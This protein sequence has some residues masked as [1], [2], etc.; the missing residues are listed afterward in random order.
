MSSR[1]E[2]EVRKLL[3]DSEDFDEAIVYASEIAEDCMCP[4]EEV[5]EEIRRQSGVKEIWP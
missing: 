4:V 2:W 3:S 1:I 5:Q